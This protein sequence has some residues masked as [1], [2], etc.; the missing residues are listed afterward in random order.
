MSWRDAWTLGCIVGALVILLLVVDGPPTPQGYRPR[1]RPG[2]LPNQYDDCPAGSKHSP[3]EIRA[4]ISDELVG[5]ICSGCRERVRLMLPP[6]GGGAG[7]RGP[8]PRRPEELRR[9]HR[10]ASVQP[11]ISTTDGSCCY[12][13]GRCKTECAHANR[14]RVM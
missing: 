12:V 8:I 11:C 2:T 10:G 4:A 5:H 7:S 1:R 13:G 6:P 14:K 3:Q 9:R